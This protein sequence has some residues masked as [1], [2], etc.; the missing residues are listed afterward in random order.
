MEFVSLSF[1]FHSLNFVR[2]KLKTVSIVDDGTLSW[3]VVPANR[4]YSMMY[5]TNGI[6]DLCLYQPNI[7]LCHLETVAHHRPKV[8]YLLS[9]VCRAAVEKKYL[10][11]RLTVFQQRG[12]YLTQMIPSKRANF[13]CNRYRVQKSQSRNTFY[14]IL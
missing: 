14:K 8:Y 1:F 11:I 3:L 6:V 2:I 7:L 10:N 13:R 9:N 5:L 4:P 12:I